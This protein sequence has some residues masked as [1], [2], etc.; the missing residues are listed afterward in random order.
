MI[1]PIK[2]PIKRLLNNIEE[3]K[4]F[5]FITLINRELKSFGRTL[6]N[7]L[8]LL[9]GDVKICEIPNRSIQNYIYLKFI[10]GVVQK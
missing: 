6:V 4:N 8:A 9:V 3:T 7:R 5:T 1:V 10:G 2:S